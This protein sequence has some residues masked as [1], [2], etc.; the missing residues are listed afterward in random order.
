MTYRILVNDGADFVTYIGTVL[1]W[2]DDHAVIELDTHGSDPS[3]VTVAMS[4]VVG[5]EEIAA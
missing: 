4:C 3:V 5:A 2:T 1:E